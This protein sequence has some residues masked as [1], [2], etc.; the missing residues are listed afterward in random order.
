MPSQEPFEAQVKRVMEKKVV[1]KVV[2]LQK[3]VAVTAWQYITANTA[4]TA[5]A[6]GSPV[7]SGRYYTSHTVSINNI[8]TNVRAPNPA[9]A[10]D[11]YKGLPISMASQKLFSLKLG[12][13][14]F[15]ANSLDYARK[16]EGG[17]SRLKA[18][19]GIYGV[20][21]EAVIA[22]FRNVRDSLGF[23]VT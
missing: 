19:E 21:V 15:I 18:P 17:W 5:L 23:T 16:L 11:P 3:A 22:K 2:E 14:V 10:D 8:D 6:Y 9:G 1:Q 20:S 7:L 12:D 13:T 4:F